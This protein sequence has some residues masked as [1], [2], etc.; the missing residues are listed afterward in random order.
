[1]DILE[2]LENPDPYIYYDMDYLVHDIETTNKE[3]GDARVEDNRML[4]GVYYSGQDTELRSHGDIFSERFK[5][6][7]QDSIYVAHNAA[8][9]LGWMQRHGIQILDLLPWDTMIA[10]YILN[11]NKRVPLDLDSIL[12]RRGLGGKESSVSLRIKAG[13]CPSSLP[14]SKLQHYCGVDVVGTRDLFLTQLMEAEERGLLGVI[15]TRC[16]LVPV[17]VGIK[18]TGMQLD[19]QRVRELEKKTVAELRETLTQ[20]QE[21]KKGINFNSPTQL[22]E[23]LYSDLK[24]AEP[25][26]RGKPSRNKPTKQFPD[27]LPKTDVDTI[28]N[29]KPT[30]KRQRKFLELFTK[31]KQVNTRM[32]KYVTLFKTAVEKDGGRIRGNFNLAIANTLRLTSSRPN[33]TNF[34]RELKPMFTVSQPDAKIVERDFAQLEYRI[35]VALGNDEYGKQSIANNVDRH[36]FT[37]DTL[38]EAGHIFKTEDPEQYRQEAKGHTFKPLFA[39]TSGTPAEQTY[40]KKFM[41]LHAGLAKVQAA[42]H[43]E[44]YTTRKLKTV[45][46]L[47]FNFESAKMN[48]AGTLIKPDGRPVDQ[49]LANYP[50]QYLSTG[51]IVPIALIF[52]RHRMRRE[53]LQSKLVNTVHDSIIAEVLNGELDIY[54]Q[55]SEQAMIK[56]TVNY[57]KQVYDF[58]LDVPLEVDISISSHWGEKQ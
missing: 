7:I 52:L 29:L 33:M 9:E 16:L 22:A 5:E 8:F 44:V 15:L 48:H 11:L 46:G 4:L 37:R 36:A 32:S 34:D 23:F 55:L 27:G 40:Y 17:I 25:T 3:N 56:D 45:T 53:L 38:L 30:N 12:K 19:V 50:I 35:A 20:M 58:I 28:S 41:E 13:I 1:M 31:Y 14:V 2:F 54:T 39:G 49:S 42:W 6:E 57:L 18:T 10:E 47:E 21:M 43:H 26:Y 51:E 24:L